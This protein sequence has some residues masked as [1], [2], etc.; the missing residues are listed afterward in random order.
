MFYLWLLVHQILFSDSKNTAVYN[1]DID[2]YAADSV[3]HFKYCNVRMQVMWC[4]G[5]CALC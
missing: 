4:G 1:S 5:G 2:H 3:P